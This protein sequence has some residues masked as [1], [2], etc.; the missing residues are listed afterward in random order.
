[1]HLTLKVITP[2]TPVLTIANLVLLRKSSSEG[3]EQGT[4]ESSALGGF[5]V[6]VRTTGETPASG[7][8]DLWRLA[9]PKENREQY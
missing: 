1:M 8:F 6:P 7:W 9:N 2:V 4:G 5:S 3:R